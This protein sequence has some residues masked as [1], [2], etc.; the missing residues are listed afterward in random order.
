MLLRDASVGVIANADAIRLGPTVS[1]AA[2][3]TVTLT[4]PH[5]PVTS[6]FMISDFSFSKA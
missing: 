4:F 3:S 5:G 6:T 2:E 1:H